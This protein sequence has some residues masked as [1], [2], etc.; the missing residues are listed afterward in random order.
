[1]RRGSSHWRAL[2]GPRQQLNR[3]IASSRMGWKSNESPVHKA[4]RSRRST[5]IPRKESNSLSC[6]HGFVVIARNA[7]GQ[8]VTRITSRRDFVGVMHTARSVLNLKLDAVRVEVHHG[9]GPTSE[10][11]GK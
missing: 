3:A 8:I 11:C 7:R 5:P 2:D 9:E 4:R 6:S 10:Y 1:M